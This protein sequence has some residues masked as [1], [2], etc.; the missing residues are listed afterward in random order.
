MRSFL[1]ALRTLVLPYGATSGRRIVLDGINGEIDLYNDSNELVG[2]ITE[3]GTT[4]AALSV[5]DDDLT[6]GG[7]LLRGDSL[8][9][10]PTTGENGE[11]LLWNMP[12]GI[13]A[14][15]IVDVSGVNTTNVLGLGE[16]G[17]T[18]V[19]GRLYK[20]HIEPLAVTASGSGT[21]GLLVKNGGSSTPSTAS[22]NLRYIYQRLTAAGFTNLGGALT[23]RCRSGGTAG[24]EIDPGLNRF[25]I[26]LYASGTT[27]TVYSTSTLNYL[28]MWWEDIGP[29]LPDTGYYNDGGGSPSGDPEASYTT[30]WNA[31]WSGSYLGDGS[32]RSTSYLYQG[33]Y[34]GY[35]PNG[36]QKSMI[37][38]NYSAIQSAL[39]GATISSCQIYLYFAHWYYN[40]G[41][42]AVLGT[43]NSSASS[44]PSSW[45]GSS[46]RKQSSG[47]PKPGGR[48]VELGTTIGN[49]LKSGAS[50]G[51][52]IGP[53]PSTSATYYGYAHGVGLSYP[54]KLKIAYT[55]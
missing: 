28:I 42:T 8:D 15:G 1:A 43:H 34:S 16:V 6:L 3:S 40:S 4:A 51:I 52:V 7:N 39:S 12:W 44:A 48:W 5:T 54:P 38:F 23:F 53:G 29:F 18:A 25:L 36:N 33:Y 35:P 55:K 26:C 14:W 27:A 31:T 45:S 2:S 20:L 24:Y 46:N 11:G 10:I 50:K 17:L 47:W 49:E 13:Q 30:T 41:G 32:H 19:A 9:Y 21:V 37:G 22:G